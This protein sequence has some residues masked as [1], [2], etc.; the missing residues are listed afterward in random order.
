MDAM[1]SLSV[2]DIAALILIGIGGIQGFFR[3]FSGELA[4]LLGTVIA[5]I[6]GTLLHEPLGQWVTANT[7]LEERPAQTLA[8][9][10]TVLVAIVIMILMRML[11]KKMITLVFAGGFD[12]SVGVLAG[13]LRMS[14]LVCIVFI[15]MNMVPVA[16]LNKHFGEESVVGRF[17]IR[18]V[19]TVEKTLEKAGMP[20]F[21]HAEEPEKPEKPE[22]P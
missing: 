1:P 13:L 12:K 10:A 2:V 5:F 3:G 4:R 20:P 22:K 9:V 7:R 18:Y 21:K 6:A 15:I 8:F 16:F 11:L 17:M 19:P 14:V